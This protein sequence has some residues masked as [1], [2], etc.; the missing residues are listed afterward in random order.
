MVSVMRKEQGNVLDFLTILITIL[1]MAVLV[2]AYLEGTGL[3]MKKLEISQISRKYILKMETE[4]YLTEAA[5]NDLVSELQDAG[6]YHI[7][8]SGTTLQPVSYGDA[9]YLKICG[10]VQ[11]RLMGSGEEMWKDGFASGLFTVE[12]EKMSTAKN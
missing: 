3:L 4:G 6:M 1:A 12:E 2:T 9:V 5:R 8:I 11:G 10:K 7:D